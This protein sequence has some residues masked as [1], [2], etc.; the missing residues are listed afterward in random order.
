LVKGVEFEARRTISIFKIERDHPREFS[1]IHN[2]YKMTLLTAV[3]I[4]SI[5]P[6]YDLV[7]LVIA[8]NVKLHRTSRQLFLMSRLT[9]RKKKQLFF[10]LPF[11]AFFVA[12]S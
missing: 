7:T 10:L 4:V 3:D 12:V 1:G 2:V 6:V 5:S 11:L 9:R 8:T